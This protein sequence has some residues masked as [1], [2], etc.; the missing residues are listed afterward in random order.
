MPIGH[1]LPKLTPRPTE[2]L[3]AINDDAIRDRTNIILNGKIIRIKFDDLIHVKYL[4]KFCGAP[5]F[6]ID[7][8]SFDKAIF[9]L[10]GIGHF[11][12]VIQMQVEKGNEV[13]N[14][15]VKELKILNSDV[16]ASRIYMESEFGLRM[17]YCPFAVITYGVLAQGGCVRII[18]E[19]MDGSVEKLK[20]KVTNLFTMKFKARNS[21]CLLPE[22]KLI[23]IK[24]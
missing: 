15:A 5:V 13:Y 1:S 9:Y 2:A 14:F 18:M 8:S 17:S 23:I 24:L 19:M 22:Y 20:M 16:R 21:P 10:I 7:G 12:E 4:G 11:A 6:D 3:V